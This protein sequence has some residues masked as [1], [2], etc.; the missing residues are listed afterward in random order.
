M[1]LAF[2]LMGDKEIMEKSIFSKYDITEELERLIADANEGAVINLPRGKFLISRKVMVENKNSLTVRGNNTTIIT[3]FDAAVGF[4]EYKGAFDFSNCNGLIF[5]NIIFDTTEN[6]NS[7]GTVIAKDLE[8]CTFDVKLFSDCALDG[9]QVIRAI[10]SIDENGSPDYLF[11]NYSDTPYELFDN[12]V[13]RIKCGEKYIEQIKR[14]PIGERVCFRHAL[15]H[16]PQLKNSAITFKNCRDIVLNDITVH[17]SAGYMITV[18]PRCHNM[19]INR[20]RVACP[21]G[22]NRL[23]ASNIDAIHIFGL[24]G[25]LSVKDCYFDGLGDDALNIHSTAGAITEIKGNKIHLINKRFSMPLEA[26]WCQKGDVIA[27][28][29][30]EFVCKGHFR[31]EEYSDSCVTATLLDGK[32][33]VGDI[34]G[35]TAFYAETEIRSCTV[36]NTRARGILLQTENIT[37]SDCSFS[38]IS[39]PAILLAPDIKTWHEVGPIKNALIE[40]CTF[41]NC[42]A[43]KTEDMLGTIAV[44]TSHN[45][46]PETEDIVHKNIIIRNNTFKDIHT[47]AVFMVS[48]DGV[49]IENN[50]YENVNSKKIRMLNCINTKIS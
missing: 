15:G 43:C 17:S 34:V 46:L 39:R 3:P 47:A 4:S 13:A 22:S 5:E 8:E 27:A 6:V 9:H 23:M 24:S 11:V 40:G 31:V 38:G 16:F 35:N 44:K 28:Y 33:E 41:E 25:K 32:A 21:E 20:Y 14:L 29:D 12:D 30:S 26:E 10:N 50:K 36:K 49:F 37:V 1:G 19:E 48:T 45:F 2:Y 42:P 7:A 18:F